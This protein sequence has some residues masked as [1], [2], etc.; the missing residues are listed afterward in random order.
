[1]TDD[2]L[3]QLKKEVNKLE[4][5]LYEKKR[6]LR[7]NCLHEKMKRTIVDIDG[8]D[9]YFYNSERDYIYECLLC[10]ESWSFININHPEFDKKAGI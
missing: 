1:M 4:D 3:Y 6:I 5:V 7:D 2:E 9:D 8:D 10:G